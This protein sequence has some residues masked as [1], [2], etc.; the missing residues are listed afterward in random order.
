MRQIIT[1]WHGATSTD[2]MKHIAIGTNINGG[3]AIWLKPVTDEEYHK[4]IEYKSISLLLIKLSGH[5]EC[6]ISVKIN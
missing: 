2:T 3:G 6:S 5:P 1:H 4:H